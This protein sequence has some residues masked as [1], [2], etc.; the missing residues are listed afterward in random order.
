MLDVNDSSADSLDWHGAQ[1]LASPENGSL[2]TFRSEFIVADV[3]VRARLYIS[4]LGFAKTWLNG[5]LVD[6]HELGQ[7]VTF[8]ER[9]LYDVVDVTAL[10]G[11]GANAIGLMLAHGWFS[12]HGIDAGIRQFRL[13]LSV[14]TTSGRWSRML[15]AWPPRPA[16]RAPY[17][18][19]ASSGGASGSSA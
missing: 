10:L 9:V 16:A 12:F 7:F 17:T 5:N 4:G 19:S 3:P 11:K 6:D 8:Q 14:T 2:N 1:W 18:R 13:L 15:S